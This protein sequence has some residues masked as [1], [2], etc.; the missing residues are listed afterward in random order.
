MRV[1]VVLLPLKAAME[2]SSLIEVLHEVFLIHYW[3]NYDV[4]MEIAIKSMFFIRDL[5]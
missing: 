5:R 2:K 3:H 4:R 1:K